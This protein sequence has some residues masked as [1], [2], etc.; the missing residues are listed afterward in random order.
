MN[1]FGGY[2]RAILHLKVPRFEVKSIGAETLML[3]L[4]VPQGSKAFTMAWP[5]RYFQISTSM[6]ILSRMDGPIFCMEV[7]IAHVQRI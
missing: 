4:A 5:G 2:Q 7:T 3:C 6:Q 1:I